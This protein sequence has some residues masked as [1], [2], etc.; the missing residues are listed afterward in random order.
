MAQFIVRRVLV[1]IPVLFGIVFIVFALAR[2]LPGDPCTASLGERATPEQCK[3]FNVRYGL[4]QPV[5]V[6]FAIYLR[7]A[8]SGDLGNSVKFGRP[9]TE[10]L[11][12]RIPVTVELSLFAL[13]FAL[14]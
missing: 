14:A 10:L 4:D 3:A 7:D 9:V 12:E 13:L 2:L 8:A 11:A 6:Q 5:L 1:S